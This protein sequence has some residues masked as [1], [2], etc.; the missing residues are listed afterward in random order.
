MLKPD[1]VYFFFFLVGFIM[2]INFTNLSAVKFRKHKGNISG[3][4]V[5]V[6]IPTLSPAHLCGVME[7]GV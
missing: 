3:Q 7:A 1:I 2:N 5:K 4:Q 6:Y